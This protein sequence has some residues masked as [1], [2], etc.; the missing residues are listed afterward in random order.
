MLG[1]KREEI[2]KLGITE[3]EVK[4]ETGLVKSKTIMCYCRISVCIQ[5]CL[6]C[7]RRHDADMIRYCQ[8]LQRD[9]RWN[10]ASS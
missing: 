2:G 3:G 9:S 4:T 1:N 6:Y 8:Y 7:L 10:V 5:R